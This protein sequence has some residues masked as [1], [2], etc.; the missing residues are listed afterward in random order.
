MERRMT[1]IFCLLSSLAEVRTYQR[2]TGQAIIDKQFRVNLWLPKESI[3]V[4]GEAETGT[5][6]WTQSLMTLMVTGK[7]RCTIAQS[8]LQGMMLASSATTMRT[9]SLCP[10][11]V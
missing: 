6:Q 10:I 8:V 1:I 4:W 11:K 9:W 5:V 3:E 2:R 7:T